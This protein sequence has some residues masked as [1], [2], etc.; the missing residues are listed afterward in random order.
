MFTISFARCFGAGLLLV[1]CVGLPTTASPVPAA[2]ALDLTAVLRLAAER[3]PEL[4]AARSA[5]RAA[6]AR[7]GF[8]DRWP[9][10]VVAA[11][12]F[13]LPVETRVG[14]QRLKVGVSQA[15]PWPGRLD[16]QAAVETARAALARQRLAAVALRIARDVR[17][18]WARLALIRKVAAVVA[19]QRKLLEDLEPTVRAR[20][21]I[22]KASYEDLQRLRLN[23]SE[24][25]ER[26]RSVLDRATMLEAAV[27]AAAGLPATATL[28]R[29]D[30]EP[31]FDSAPALPSVKSMRAALRNHPQ[32]RV[33]DARIATARAETDRTRTLDQPDVVFG[34]DWVMVGQARMAGV[35][36]SGADALLARVGMRLPVWRSA[37]AAAQQAAS[38]RVHVERGARQAS[39]RRAEARLERLRYVMRDARHKR[40][41][42]A[43]DLIPRARSALDTALASFAANRARFSDLIEFEQSLLDYRIRLARAEADWVQARAELQLLLGQPVATSGGTP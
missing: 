30:F 4:Q 2:K 42:Y 27:R 31:G 10:P 15:M 3:S 40:R 35:Q 32:V 37:Y 19:G 6:S 25:S 39:L 34:L 20:F 38:E 28:A 1:L 13:I 11:G 29:A 7:T 14:P 12:A 26:Q 21:S 41:L 5:V 43:L 23:I 9:D 24:L 17:V 22:G 8:V 36:D 18:P 16:S 33:A